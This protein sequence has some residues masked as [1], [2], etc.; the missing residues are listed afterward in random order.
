MLKDTSQPYESLY[1]VSLT[2]SLGSLHAS[3]EA[4]RPVEWTM[5]S[6]DNLL[7]KI[8]PKEAVYARALDSAAV[9]SI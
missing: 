4:L 3:A 1:G 5:C 6:I 7:N 9:T 8:E 2:V